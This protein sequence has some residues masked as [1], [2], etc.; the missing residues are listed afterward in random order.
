MEPQDAHAVVDLDHG[1]DHVAQVAVIA[2]EL[3]VRRAARVHAVRDVAGERLEDVAAARG[4]KISTVRTQ[5]AALLQK[6]GTPR[7]SALVGLL[8]RLALLQRQR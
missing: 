8:S 2:G 6:T 4:V 1:A 3:V 7:Q 5:L